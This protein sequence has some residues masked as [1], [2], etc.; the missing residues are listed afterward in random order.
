M[1]KID[2]ERFRLRAFA[3]QLVEAGECLVHD[4]PID[5]IDVAAVLDGEPRAVWFRSVGP[6]K[7]E[8]IGNVMGARSRLAMALDVDDAQFAAKL[9]AR[10]TGGIAPVEVSQDEAPVQQVVLTGTQADLCAL[11][12]HLQHELD[13]AP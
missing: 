10:S 12:V 7:T 5:L 9:R 13:G 2:F 11:P 8:L 4:A 3:Q 1:S 6:E